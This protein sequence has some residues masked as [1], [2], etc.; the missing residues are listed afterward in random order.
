MPTPPARRSSRSTARGAPT[1][2][3]ASWEAPL[4]RR[5][6]DSLPGAAQ[7]LELAHLGRGSPLVVELA[8]GSQRRLRL[9]ASAL[10]HEHGGAALVAQSRMVHVAR[11]ARE[12]GRPLILAQRRA[13]VAARLQELRMEQ[14]RHVRE[15]WTQAGPGAELADAAPEHPQVVEPLERAP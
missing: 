11:L 6:P 12:L 15:V 9:G 2:S 13:R 8:R 5:S 4:R 10:A 3:C 1:P 14:L 7:R